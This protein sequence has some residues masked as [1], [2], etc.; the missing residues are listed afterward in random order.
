MSV[1]ASHLTGSG[2]ELGWWTLALLAA[3]RVDARADEVVG[4]VLA[5]A[6]QLGIALSRQGFALTPEETGN[7]LRARHA[8][9]LAQ[10]NVING[11]FAI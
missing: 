3:M 1:L 6:E 4:R 10:R 9:L 8:A 5:Q 7:E 11:S 2:V